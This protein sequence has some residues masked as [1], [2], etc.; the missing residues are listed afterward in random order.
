MDF[1]TAPD[2]G[3]EKARIT[4]NSKQ[5]NTIG[6]RTKMHRSNGG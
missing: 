1:N 5:C 6:P 2:D 3:N 4:I